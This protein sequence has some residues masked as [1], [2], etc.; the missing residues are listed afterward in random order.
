MAVCNARRCDLLSRI[1]DA[2][3]EWVKVENLY[4]FDGKPVYSL[5]QGQ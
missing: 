2:G 1:E 5:G 4:R 3:F